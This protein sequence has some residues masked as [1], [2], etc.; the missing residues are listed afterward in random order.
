MADDAVLRDKLRKIEALFA[1]ATTP[2][3]KAARW[4]RRRPAAPRPL[5]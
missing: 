2:G 3:E 1:G 5:R 4:R